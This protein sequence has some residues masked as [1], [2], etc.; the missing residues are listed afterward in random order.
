MFERE[1][2]PIQKLCK[3]VKVNRS[4]YYKWL[5]RTPSNSQK[6]NEEILG[7]VHELYT[8][9]D[10]I[11][12][13]RQMTIVINREYGRQYNHKRIYR[14]MSLVGL[15]SVTR[16]KRKNYIPSTPEVTAKNILNREFYADKPNEK[17]LT[18]VT[19]FKYGHILFACR[20]FSNCMDLQYI[21]VVIYGDIECSNYIKFRDVLNEKTDIRKKYED[22]KLQ[23]S[24]EFP[25]NR[26]K[27]TNMKEPF[28]QSILNG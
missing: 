25:L 16:K 20:D 1:S 4:T 17:W 23:L 28:I 6:L 12:G 8:E 2:Y 9:V 13:Y 26:V 15:Q 5:K 10:G 7:I 14:L 22:L 27:Y 19:E 11:L 24:E 21:H 18:D 3:S